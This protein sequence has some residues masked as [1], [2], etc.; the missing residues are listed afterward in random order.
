MKMTTLVSFLLGC[1]VT[2]L[3]A[4]AVRPEPFATVNRLERIAGSMSAERAKSIPEQQMR[5]EPLTPEKLEEKRSEAKRA[6]EKY[7]R[8]IDEKFDREALDIVMTDKIAKQVT[9]LLDQD[10]F[11]G[12]ELVSFDCRDTMC[13]AAIKVSSVLDAESVPI[14]FTRI[15]LVSGGTLRRPESA[16]DR[17]LIAFL[18]RAGHSLP[19]RTAVSVR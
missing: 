19:P 9:A 2:L 16:S 1:A 8:Q 10:Q 17:V 3:I 14:L 4:V 13:R 5:V 7:F 6:A 12:L 18:E 11:K 15:P